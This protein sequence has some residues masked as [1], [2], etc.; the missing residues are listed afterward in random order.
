MHLT[1][2]GELCFP[3]SP[4]STYLAVGRPQHGHSPQL[5]CATT[6]VRAPVF[7][8]TRKQGPVPAES[9]SLANTIRPLLRAEPGRQ[10]PNWA[11]ANLIK[12]E[13]LIHF[14][15]ERNDY[16]RFEVDP[17]PGFSYDGELLDSQ[18]GV[19]ANMKR[20]GTIVKLKALKAQASR[21]QKALVVAYVHEK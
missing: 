1:F 14:R 9:R 5:D 15:I 10:R 2:R 20:H 19:A 7:G 3:P 18:Y 4:I 6:T 17:L 12:P 13:E 21:Q 11:K 8:S 16:S